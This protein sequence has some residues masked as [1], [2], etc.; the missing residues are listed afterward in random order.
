MRHSIAHGGN[1]IAYGSLAEKLPIGPEKEL[2]F[3]KAIELEPNFIGAHLGLAMTHVRMGKQEAGLAR[4]QEWV[5]RA[6]DNPQVLYAAGR[7]LAMAKRYD[8]AIRLSEAA[9]EFAPGNLEY[10][11]TAGSIAME[12]QRFGKV[13]ELLGPILQSNP[14]YKLTGLFLGSALVQLGRGREAIPVLV[15]FVTRY[16]LDPRGWY[17]L[18]R[19]KM[20][21][22]DWRGAA[23]AFE[24]CLRAAPDFPDASAQLATCRRKLGA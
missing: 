11:Y 1:N 7:I 16:G 21:V 3:R 6:P 19:A 10:R 9:V 20:S 15:V 17:E 18:G 2:M 5:N 12:A 23:E 4:L 13:L 24:G 22:E 8:D 14:G